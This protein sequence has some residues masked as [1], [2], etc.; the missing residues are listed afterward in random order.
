V[1]AYLVGAPR[2]IHTQRPG[3]MKKFGDFILLTGA[4]GL[5]GQY[6]LR[7]LLARGHRVAIVVRGN[8]KFTP[9]QRMEQTMQMWERDAGQPL[10]RPICLEGNITEPDLNLDDTDLKWIA[11]NCGSIIHSAASLTFHTQGKEPWCT[12]VEGTQNVLDVCQKT[13]I[14]HMH[15]ISTAYICGRRTDLVMED[16]VDVGQEFR[17]DYEKS[18]FEAEKRVRDADCFD[19]M[20]IYRPVVITGDSETGYTSTY[21]GTYLYMRLAKLLAGNVEPD[22]E[23]SR[24]VPVRWGANGDERRNITPVDWNSDIICQ[25]FENRDAHGHTFHLGP[26]HPATTRDAIEFASRFYGLTGIEFGGYGHTPD[27]PLNDLEK[28]IWANISIYGDYDF[29][30]PEFDCTNLKKFAPRPACPKIDYAIA[31]RLL[32]Y[33]ENDRWGKRKPTPI[34]PP[35]LCVESFLKG[36]V[37]NAVSEAEAITIGLEALGPGGGPWTLTISETSLT[38]FET[39]LPLVELDAPVVQIPMASLQAIQDTPTNA[40]DILARTANTNNGADAEADREA[41]RDIRQILAAALS[42]PVSAS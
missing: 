34:D 22:E 33:A 37:Q 2:D 42:V 28:W 6:L 29:T 27:R 10:P 4:T 23:G 35:L 36:F 15:Y 38:R 18:K 9:Q 21:H 25:L 12:N 32:E 20:T 7:D 11:E 41:D 26:D 1:D 14:R 30:D 3:H 17:N 16:T 8:K 24:H 31:E 19:C 13:S 39:G 40:A 5:L